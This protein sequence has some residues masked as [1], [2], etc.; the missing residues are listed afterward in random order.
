MKAN[1]TYNHNASRLV[2][3]LGLT[4]QEHEIYCQK[5]KLLVSAMFEEM[6]NTKRL[7]RSRV[8]E[9]ISDANL[10]P[11]DLILLAAETVHNE[12]KEVE[13]VHIRVMDID[14]FMKFMLKRRFDKDGHTNGE[15]S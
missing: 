11:E 1:F 5:I 14:K 7:S 3:A 15:D 6:S 9:M 10:T 4:E 8:I 13:S 12:I 2:E